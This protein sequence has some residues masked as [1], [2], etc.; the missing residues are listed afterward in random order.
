MTRKEEIAVRRDDY[1]AELA[2]GTDRFYLLRRASCPWC[3][4][5]ILRERLRTTDLVQHKPGRFVLDECQ[6]CGHVFQNPRLTPEGL[7]FYY[8][9]FY[10][11]LGEE[12]TAKLFQGRG[13]F[14]RFRA[15]ARAMLRLAQPGKWLDVGTSH[16]HF[17]QAAA[18]VLP[19]TV[20]D[21]L[22]NCEGVERAVTEGRIARAYRGFFVDLV[23]E[24]TERYDVVS[25]FHYL[26]HTP[27]P[28]QELAAARTAL[29]AGG[30]LMIEVPD[31]ES[32]YGRLLGRWWVPWLQPQH[33][34]L[35]PMANLCRELEAQGFTV[36]ATDRQQPHIPADLV[37]ATWFLLTRVLPPEDAPWLPERPR[38]VSRL[39]RVL[40]V[41]AAAP[42]LFAAWAADQ[43]LAPLVRR[44]R[45][46]NAYR[47]IARRD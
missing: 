20:F 10:D 44:T 26:E 4:S 12:A 40:L 43:L 22:D 31:P 1:R 3:A 5:P 9:D 18:T 45:L 38:F 39:A 8:R 2:D 14:K 15:S 25:M 16:G 32:T 37:C 21:G 33:L 34:H 24:M 17:C 7:D 46:A 47:I 6:A 28:K 35:M 41:L 42:F 29:R 23:E 27:D 30:H 11:G 36:M 19:T 13:S